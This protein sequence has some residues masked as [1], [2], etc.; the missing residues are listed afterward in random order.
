M[1]AELRVRA[2][3]PEQ[4][5]DAQA[6]AYQRFHTEDPDVLASGSDLW[7][8]PIALSG[9]L[10]V[11]G[12]VD[13]DESD[14]DDLRLT[15]QPSYAYAPPP[16]RSKPQ[17]LLTTYYVP[18]QGQN[19]VATL[20][21]WVDAQGR[22]RLVSRSLPRDPVTLGPAQVSRLVFATPRVRNLLGLRN[23]EIRD[24]DRSSLDSVILGIPHLLFLPGGPMQVQSL[25]EGSRG[26]G[27]ARLL[28]VT[29]FVNGR[30]GLGP[31]MA[32]ALRQ[33]LNAPPLVDVRRPGGPASVGTP[34]ALH[35][36]VENARRE[37]V[38][39]T[40]GTEHKV[41][42]MSL[43]SG[44]GTVRWTPTASGT[45]RVRVT[46]VGLDGTRVRDAASF[47]VLS[48]PPVIRLVSTPGRAVV[49]R[50][51]RVSFTVAHGRHA[52][53]RVSTLSGIVFTRDY[54]LRNHRGV[55][56]WTPEVAGPAVVL[57]RARGRQGQIASASLRLQVRPH[58]TA[59]SPS[60]ELLRVPSDL[61]T[62]TPATFALRADGCRVAVARI[63]GPVD[64]VPEFRFPCP[65]RRGTFAWTP[66]APGSYLLTAE[67]RGPHGLTASQRVRLDVA[68]DPL[69]A[70][71]SAPS[72]GAS[73]SS[74]RGTLRLRV[75]RP[76]TW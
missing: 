22:P 53:V 12:G 31:D 21:G 50:P 72:A 14:E 46:V 30:A 38:T 57:V 52:S 5:F 74:S 61:V 67:A 37:I 34:V 45:A 26:P 66:G 4:L 20:S 63:S 10:E 73:P 28:G 3:Y 41:E 40:S 51:V 58:T 36:R 35:F 76:E 33:A 19:L 32:D 59:A 7:S 71:S 29:V 18:R 16:G 65:V 56:K 69:A 8:R 24:L 27:A 62:G 55:V 15:M 54:L 44:T 2:R 6:A 75:S 47:R 48:R 64:D 39:I 17:L 25:F 11:A 13:F 49:G 43:A 68:S 1:P 42:R 70:P 23:L 60:V 9:P